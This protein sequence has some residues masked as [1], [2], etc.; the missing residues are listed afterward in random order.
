MD[1]ICAVSIHLLPHGQQSI[2]LT[3]AP[4]VANRDATTATDGSNVRFH[5]RNSAA[6]LFTT[7]LASRT[8]PKLKTV[9]KLLGSQ[10]VLRNCAVKW[11]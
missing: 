9:P 1:S 3:S 11:L 2:H 6:D 10:T 7:T 5:D 4:L 8:F